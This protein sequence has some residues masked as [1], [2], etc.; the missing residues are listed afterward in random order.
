MAP[1]NHSSLSAPQVSSLQD[2]TIIEA[3]DAETNKSKYITFYVVT[4]DEEVYFGQS[5][6][7]KRDMTLAE[8]RSALA[9]IED[10]EIYPEYPSMSP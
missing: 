10:A 7:N 3:W 9:R 6:K 5:F 2:L 4:P 1:S 8:Y